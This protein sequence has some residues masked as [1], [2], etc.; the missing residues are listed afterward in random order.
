GEPIPAA[1][2]EIWKS[3]PLDRLRLQ[4]LPLTETTKL[5]SETLG[6]HVDLEAAQR[7]W[8]LTLG[9][10]LY[11]TNIV[12][13]ETADGRVKEVA[14]RWR[15]T[16]DPVMP[17]DLVELIESR[18]GS[19]PAPVGLVL[20]VLAV[21]EPLELTILRQIA[22]P[23]AVEEAEVRG[24]IALHATNTGLDVRIS[25]PIY[26]EVRRRR[27]PATTLRRLRGLVANELAASDGRD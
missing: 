22:D 11:L 21:G 26:G 7:L 16:G 12:E 18:I 1:V 14:G 27:A 25:H 17:P 8:T 13:Q 3:G 15:W 10:V 6:G 24:L 9:N 2:Q 19:L 4:P 5:L 23:D 20:D